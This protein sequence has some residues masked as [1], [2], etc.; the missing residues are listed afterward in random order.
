MANDKRMDCVILGLLSHE[1]LTGYDIKKRLDTSLRFFWSGSFGSIYPTLN[2]LVQNAF[3]QKEE[4]LE[5][6]REKIIYSIT[7]S[8]RD[9]LVEWLKQPVQKDELR[10]ET[11]LKLFFGGELGKEGSLEHIHRF[12][13]KIKMDLQTLQ[14]F[15]NNLRRVQAEDD[16]HKY[17]L[18]TVL[19]GIETYNGYLRWCQQVREI[20]GGES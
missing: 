1:S 19:F 2:K 20:L 8:G 7:E 5:K 16:D 9:F 17:Y 12:E 15:E 14:F 11:L 18:A 4:T 13:E 6:G 10:Y 3:I